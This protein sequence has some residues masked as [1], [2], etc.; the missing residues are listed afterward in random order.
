MDD[1]QGHPFKLAVLAKDICCVAVDVGEWDLLVD[2]AP[3]PGHSLGSTYN[4]LLVT[5]LTDTPSSPYLPSR[6]YP[7]WDQQQ[8]RR[9]TDVRNNELKDGLNALRVVYLRS[10]PEL[11]ADA[12]MGAM[13]VVGKMGHTTTNLAEFVPTYMECVPDVLEA[14]GSALMSLVR[15][16]PGDESVIVEHFISDVINTVLTSLTALSKQKPPAFGSILLL[17][18]VAYPHA[19]RPRAVLAD[20]PNSRAMNKAAVKEK[21][22]HIFDLLEEVTERHRMA[23]VLEDE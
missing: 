18:N 15:F 2:M 9:S 21:F 19:P 4:T 23:R 20:D 14:V 6:L 22:T 7:R 13:G 1:K 17:N 8:Q 10:F 3:I 5:L 11:I 12:K 16:G